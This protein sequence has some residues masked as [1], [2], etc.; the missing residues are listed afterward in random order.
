MKADAA[1]MDDAGELVLGLGETGDKHLSLVGGKA[2]NLGKLIAAGLPVPRGFCLTT[3][4]FDLFLASCP[5]RT[6]LSRLL[7]QCSGDEP[8][9]IAELIREI[10]SWLAEVGV[11]EV[12]KHAALSAWRELGEERSFAVRSSATVEDA[13]GMSFAGQFE[14]ILNV[15]GADALLDAI[16]SCW[17]SLFSERAL[18]YLAR[19]RVPAEKVK[20]AVLV[21]EMVDASHAGVVFTA[22]PLTGATDRFVVECVSGLGEGLVQGTVQPERVVVDKRTGRALASPE[23][24]LLSSATLENL[25]DLAR[26]TENLFGSPQDIEWAQRD[27][28]VFLLQSRP[29]TTKVPVRTWEDRQIWTNVNTGEAFPDAMT[30]MT[31]SLVRFLLNGVWGPTFHRL[32]G[33][34][35]TRAPLVGLV[36]GRIYFNVNTVLAAVKPFSVLLKG[37]PDWVQELGGVSVE[38]Y[39]QGPQSIPPEDLPDLGFT[40]SKYILSWP[41]LVCFLIPRLSRQRGAAWLSRLEARTD[42]LVRRDVEVMSTPELTRFLARLAQEALQEFDLLS[43]EFD[44]LHMAMQ[45][46]ALPVFQKACR[47]WLGDPGLPIRLFAAL[48]GMPDAEAGRALWR[49]AALARADR[50]LETTVASA[51]NWLEMRATLGRTQPGQKFLAAWDAFMTEHGHHCRGEAE[52]FNA[53]W[54]ETPDYI[55]GLARGYLRSTAGF[56]PLEN[57]RQ[58]AE[59]RER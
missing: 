29:I 50:D 40:W 35:L 18:I 49:L 10:R 9:R 13:A 32:L 43:Q 28:G 1:I 14:S 19:Q 37:S 27:G 51:S 41:R 57:Q 23:N 36:A 6:D 34:D 45:T 5:R 30:P 39:C 4:A 38:A 33:V 15:R 16:K 26:R 47:G 44:L 21:Q 2:F 22:D 58:L 17:L 52:L 59:E 20:M 8:G 25:C 46:M 54:S 55:L 53:R 11:P 24:E 56:D 31:W 12:V 42:E 3:T 48:G 7:A